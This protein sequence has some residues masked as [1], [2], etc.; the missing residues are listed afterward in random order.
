VAD[1]KDYV[2]FYPEKMDAI[3]EFPSGS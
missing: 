3:E 2:A 1:I